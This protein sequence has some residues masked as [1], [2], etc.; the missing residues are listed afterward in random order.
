M[1]KV[2]AILLCFMVFLALAGC[3]AEK[4]SFR[5]EDLG[6]DVKMRPGK[7]AN[8]SHENNA[9]LISN[10]E[11]GNTLGVISVE[12]IEGKNIHE[13][14]DAYIAGGA[15]EITKTELSD[16]LIFVDI[17][18]EVYSEVLGNSVDKMYCFIFYDES[19][20]TVLYG[21]FFEDNER[22]YVIGLAKSIEVVKT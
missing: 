7:Q 1:K 21:R 10:A 12:I 19:I 2:L 4:E 18:N 9:M 20:G 17:L 16:N 11:N 6:I 22:D 5:I 8:V 14:Y 3:K 15:G 13:I